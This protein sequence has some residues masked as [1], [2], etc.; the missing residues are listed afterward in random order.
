MDL[1][2][3]TRK[4]GGA[5][6]VPWEED[7]GEYGI[8]YETTDGQNGADRIGTKKQAQAIIRDIA[9]SASNRSTRAQIASAGFMAKV[10][11]GRAIVRCPATLRP[12]RLR[13]LGRLLSE[14]ALIARRRFRSWTSTLAEWL[15]D[16]TSYLP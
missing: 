8:A 9:K 5:K 4:I 2:V 3:D 6:V 11:R 14:T 7:E 1:C 10:P 13:R 15:A 16:R 12:L